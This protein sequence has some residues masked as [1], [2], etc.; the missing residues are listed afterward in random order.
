MQKFFEEFENILK[1]LGCV[2][3]IV[4]D[5]EVVSEFQASF[6]AALWIN[7]KNQKFEVLL[8]CNPMPSGFVSSKQ[9]FSQCREKFVLSEIVWN[10]LFD[11]SFSIYTSGSTGNAKK[12][13]KTFLQMY[14]EGIFLKDFL[15]KELQLSVKTI[16]CCVPLYHLF[17]LSFGVIL[18][19]VLKRDSYSVAPFVESILAQKNKILI[20]SPVILD[21]MLKGGVSDDFRE[22]ELIISAG[23]PLKQEIRTLLKTKTNA[24]I[25]DIYGSSE[26][27]VIAY[28]LEN[29]LKKFSVVDLVM[30]EKLIVHSPWCERFESEDIV[31]FKD[32]GFVIL[33]RA[34]RV[35][36]LADKRV[37][38]QILEDE[39]RQKTTILRDCVLMPRHNKL[40]AYVVLNEEGIE[41][42]KNKGKKGIF[43]QLKGCFETSWILRYLEIVEQIPKNDLGK[44]NLEALR[45]NTRDK[46]EFKLIML[47]ENLET[48]RAVF[49]G[50]ISEELFFF[51]GHFYDFPLVPGFVE[52]DFIFE[53]LGVFGLDFTCVKEIVQVKFTEFLRP[54]DLCNLILEIKGDKLYFSIKVLDKICLNGRAKI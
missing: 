17:G 41:Y 43:N 54:K 22:V 28:S 31:E 50:C 5:N 20:V 32:D 45:N 4:L 25:L 38:L 44:I 1:D 13:K 30:Q 53:H 2:S 7:L 39:I 16:G 11:A 15:E 35:I 19:L 26:T 24:L 42:F 37:D 12:I 3:G 6:L 40:C 18:P 51:D 10:E 52:L 29:R 27:G 33:G 36:K 14:N 47:K 8:N 46:Q 23:S 9:V 34:D 49:E 21:A 48:K